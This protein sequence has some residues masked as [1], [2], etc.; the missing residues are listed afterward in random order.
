MMG[1]ADAMRCSVVTFCNYLKNNLLHNTSF[2]VASITNK[3]IYNPS[4]KVDTGA[5]QTFIRENNIAA[6]KGVKTI[7]NGPKVRLPNNTVISPIAIGELPFTNALSRHANSLD[8][9][10]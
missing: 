8:L 1:G 3:C 10:K 9:K 5:S 7:F 6:L 2:S 4:L